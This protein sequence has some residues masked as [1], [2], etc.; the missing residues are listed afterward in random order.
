MYLP[1]CASAS[2][3]RNRS[4][5]P[6]FP[7]VAVQDWLPVV[8]SLLPRTKNCAA[9]DFCHAFSQSSWLSKPFLARL[10]CWWNNF[11]CQSKGECDQLRHHPPALNVYVSGWRVYVFSGAAWMVLQPAFQWAFRLSRSWYGVGTAYLDNYL[12]WFRFMEEQS[13]WHSKD[14]IN[15]SFS[16]CGKGVAFC[17]MNFP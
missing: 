12:A 13:K 3:K 10:N 9:R 2:G 17:H 11:Y 16:H 8:S 4:E 14:W 15:F 6:L 7:T 5:N 1:W